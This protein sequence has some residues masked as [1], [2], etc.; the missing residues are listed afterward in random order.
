M[1]PQGFALYDVMIALT[2][3]ALL[4]FIA[5]PSYSAAVQKA[6]VSTA[7]GDMARIET[8]LVR[9]RSNGDGALPANLAAI[10]MAAL[11]DPWGNPY[12]YLNIEAGAN[13]GAVRK[14]RNLVPINTDY[15]LYSMGKDGKSVPPLTAKASRDD[16]VR[17]GNGGF[18]GLAK[19][20]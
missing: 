15:D 19:D 12:Q 18:L 9:F 3:I 1:R 20:Y 4:A 16:I 5:L 11:N 17:G 6:R 2:V 7:I 8:A 14:N 13:R 10:G